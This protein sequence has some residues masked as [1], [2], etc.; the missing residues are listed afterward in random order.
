MRSAIKALSIVLLIVV[1]GA[2]ICKHLTEPGLEGRW[3]KKSVPSYMADEI[4]VR[5]ADGKFTESYRAKDAAGIEAI[6]LQLDG[7]EHVWSGRKQLGSF[8]VSPLTVYWAQLNGNT[9]RVTKHVQSTTFPPS[10][11]VEQW[12]L[13]KRGQQ[14]VIS[15][16]EST[17]VYEK[18]SVL[19]KLFVSGV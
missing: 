5:I 14:L 16:P 1:A 4:R 17:A 3:L 10:T 7:K 15:S 6:T 2:A 12:S 13:Q 8:E 18:E 9:L 11:Y 19:R